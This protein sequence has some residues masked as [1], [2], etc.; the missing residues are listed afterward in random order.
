MSTDDLAAEI[1]RRAIVVDAHADTLAEVAH[2]AFALGRENQVG[3]WDIPRARL[4]N[5]GVQFFTVTD[6]AQHVPRAMELVDFAY[7]QIA[8]FPEDLRLITRYED[9]SE[10]CNEGKIGMLLSIEGGEA[11]GG[12][13]GL[14]R[15]FHR[16]GV[17]AMGLTWNRRNELADGVLDAR[18]KGGLSEFGAQ[19]VAEMESLGMLVDVSHLSQA[20]FWDVDAIANRP[21]IASHSNARALCDHPRNLTDSQ[22]GAIAARGGVIGINFCPEFLSEEGNATIEDVIS[23]IDYIARLAGVEHVGLGSD[24]DGINHTPKGL[25]NVARL[26]L[27]TREL[28]GRGYGEDAILAILGGNFLRVLEACMKPAAAA[29]N[30]PSTHQ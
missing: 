12:E 30:I 28:L 14:L 19:V 2:G 11:L 15:N 20:G 29:H 7:R 27:I 1:H 21:Y 18:S 13:L 5:V 25:E 9:I 24:F 16:L 22:I 6:F 10:A 3:H 17:R 26:P 4:G 8:A 23:H